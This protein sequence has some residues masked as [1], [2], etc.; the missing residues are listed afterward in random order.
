M[1]STHKDKNVRRASSESL[2]GI[3]RKDP[4]L[5]FQV[6]ENLKRDSSLYVRKSVANIMRDASKADP[7]LVFKNANISAYYAEVLNTSSVLEAEL[8]QHD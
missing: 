4:T 5:V 6:L 7:Q 2:R 1:R 8:F 3:A